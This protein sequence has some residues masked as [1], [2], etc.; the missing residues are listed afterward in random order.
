MTSETRFTCVYARNNLRKNSNKLLVAMCIGIALALYGCYVQA[1]ARIHSNQ[2]HSMNGASH[3]MNERLLKPMNQWRGACSGSQNNG[4]HHNAAS[5]VV[6]EY[7]V[8][9]FIAQS[10]LINGLINVI[11]I[12]LLKLYCSSLPATNA[13]VALSVVGLCLSLVC[14]IGALAT[15]KMM[16]VSCL[17]LHHAAI[18]WFALQ[19]R[20]IFRSMLCPP[21]PGSG[22]SSGPGSSESAKTSLAAK[23]T[24]T[25]KTTTATGHQSGATKTVATPV[26][27]KKTLPGDNESSPNSDQSPPA[28]TSRI[29]RLSRGSAKNMRRRRSQN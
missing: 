28:A 17:G 24:T 27:G 5:R 20:A 18:I 2:V 19:R 25:T 29:A 9:P 23:A 3:W 16:C 11:Q 7:M 14:L 6:M 1:R 4:A 21:G 22:L 13:I 8:R 26:V 10:G 15:C 12:V